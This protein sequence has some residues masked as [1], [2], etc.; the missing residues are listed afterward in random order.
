[1][2]E[3]DP[4]K[5]NKHYGEQNNPNMSQWNQNKQK[6]VKQIPNGKKATRQRKGK[7]HD[8]QRNDQKQKE[9]KKITKTAQPL[10]NA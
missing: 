5:H 7:P 6:A 9:A 2:G 4:K 10:T 8:G 3:L 1:M